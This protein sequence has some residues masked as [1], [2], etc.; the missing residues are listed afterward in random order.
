MTNQ[1]IPWKKIYDLALQCCC[2][3]SV[4]TFSVSLLREMNALVPFDEASIFYL[5]GNQKVTDYYLYK[6]DPKWMSLYLGYYANADGGGY[7]FGQRDADKKDGIYVHKWKLEQSD[8]FIPDYVRPQNLVSSLG[9][10]M[11]DASGR[12]RTCFAF[13]R[14]SNMEFSEREIEIVRAIRNLLKLF[15]QL[16]FDRVDGVNEQNLCCPERRMLTPREA[17]IV[18]LLEQGLSPA[19][20]AHV[21]HITLPTTN[22]HIYNVYKKLNVSS[23]VELM[24]KLNRKG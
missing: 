24:A 18:N 17:E 15:H 6:I 11:R 13:D 8:E 3:R 19:N 12:I 23:R 9:F 5:D 20:I 4:K 21:L 10:P 1:E 16:L 14:L 7:G 22:R 2:T